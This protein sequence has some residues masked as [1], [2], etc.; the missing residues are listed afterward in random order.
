MGFIY[1]PGQGMTEPQI[2]QGNRLVNLVTPRAG[3]TFVNEQQGTDSYTYTNISNDVSNPTELV[4]TGGVQWRVSVKT[5][6]DI[7][8]VWLEYHTR[9]NLENAT[10]D[11]LPRTFVTGGQYGTGA[12]PSSWNYTERVV[13]PPISFTGQFTH[14]EFRY[15]GQGTVL[16]LAVNT[17][18]VFRAVIWC[19]GATDADVKHNDTTNNS[20]RSL[21][22]VLHSF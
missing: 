22:V 17:T 18:Y 11:A 8:N 6:P 5:G 4:G 2:K 19:V 16:P 15:I 3:T 9:F 10:V 12:S 20:F 1:E 21:V 14:N 7:T 13:W